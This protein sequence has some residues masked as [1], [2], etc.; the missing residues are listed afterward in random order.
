MTS[1]RTATAL[2]L[3]LVVL[4]GTSLAAQAAVTT[5]GT[6]TLSETR[7]YYETAGSGPPVVLI[8]AFGLN[9]HQWDDQVKALAAHYRVIAYDRRG[10]GK[11]TGVADPS[12]EPADLKELLD[13]LGVRSAVLVGH[14]GGN[15][16]AS[17]FV[18]AFADRVDGLVLYPSPPVP[19]FPI[20]PTGPPGPDQKVL[21]RQYGLDSMF[22]LVLARPEF[23]TPPNRPDINERILALTATYSGRDLLEDHVQAGTYRLLTFEEMQA[24][25]TPTL[26]IVGEWEQPQAILVSD[27]M[28]RWMPNARSVMIRGG[29]RIV[30]FAEPDRFNEALLAFLRSLPPSRR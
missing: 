13:S 18:K 1:N 30:H 19:G 20:P 7:I 3:S 26:F 16:T 10:F 4:T 25:P 5:S 12:L 2:T 17:R 29:G 14:S 15:S 23:R 22:K 6:I 21:T 9:L 24:L 11:S 28:A 27:S 8:H